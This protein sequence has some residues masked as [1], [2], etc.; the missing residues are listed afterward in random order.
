MAWWLAAA[1][2]VQLYGQQRANRDQAR[3]E[4]ANA[5]EYEAQKRLSQMAA[6][7]EADIFLT[8]SASFIGDQV[9]ELAKSG[10]QMDGSVLMELAKSRGAASREYAA[11]QAGAAGQARQFD[12]RAKSA[13]SMA[14]RVSSSSFNNIQTLGTLLNVGGDYA[15]MASREKKYSIEG[16]TPDGGYSGKY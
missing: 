2:V 16:N 6:R 5:K 1:G 12:I 10:I 15:E 14:N 8:D 9:S 13:R 11:I 3:A 4:R 7:R